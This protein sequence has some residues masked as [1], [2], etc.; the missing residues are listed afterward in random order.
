MILSYILYEHFL[1]WG[2][3][4]FIISGQ[5]SL[6][7]NIEKRLIFHQL[8]SAE[9]TK[10]CFMTSVSYGRVFCLESQKIDGTELKGID[11]FSY[12]LL[13]NLEA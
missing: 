1:F 3:K 12:F 11:R 2:S 4:I 9:I 8:L 5:N 13:L 6:F 7:S 10:R